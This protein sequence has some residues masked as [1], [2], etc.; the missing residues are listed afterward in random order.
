MYADLFDMFDQIVSKADLVMFC[1]KWCI[2]KKLQLHI[3]IYIIS[4]R[5]LYTHEIIKN[6]SNHNEDFIIF[7]L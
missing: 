3:Q 1:V 7:G 6:S 2:K 5:K 4:C